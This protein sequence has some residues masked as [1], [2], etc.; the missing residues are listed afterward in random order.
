MIPKVA[1]DLDPGHSLHGKPSRSPWCWLR[2]GGLHRWRAVLGPRLLL[3][4]P[5]SWSFLEGHT[6]AYHVS[7]DN[8]TL[9]YTPPPRL[10]LR[11]LLMMAH[12]KVPTLC[13]L[14]MSLTQD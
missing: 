7:Q 3:S 13:R 6:D 2:V 8:P 9:E 11:I 4:L 1:M 14:V 5:F 12:K 10:H